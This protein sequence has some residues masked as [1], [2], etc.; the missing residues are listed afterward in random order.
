DWHHPD[1]LTENHSRYVEYLH[2]QVRELLT[3]YGKI[4]G[5][6]FDNLR[7][8]SPQ[9][10]KL[11][12]AERL[13]KTARTLQ[14][15]LIINNRCGLSGDYDTPEQHVGRIQF[16]RPWESCITLGTQWAWKPDDKLKP[17]TDAIRMLVACA[18]GN[19]NLALNTNPMPDGRI[20]P[21][22][23]ESFRKIGKWLKK[24]G[25]SIYE[26]RGGPFVAPDAPRRK[27]GSARD[28]FKLS[29][30]RWWGG[31]THKND[32]IYLHIL[33]WPEDTITLPPIKHKI[34]EHA[35]LTGGKATIRQTADQITV[36]VPPEDRD[37]LDTIVKLR[38]DGPAS[39]IPPMKEP[40]SGSLA[41][42][43]EA[44]ASNVYENAAEYAASRAFDD[45]PDTRW[46][47]D[48]GTH[49]AWLAVDLGEEMTF[50]SARIS[51]PYDR[52]RSFEL[53][54]KKNGS[55][56]TFHKGTT[57]GESRLIEFP[58]ITARH[59]RLNLT[60]TTEGPSIWEFQIFP[61]KK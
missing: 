7:A 28:Q 38:L 48:W 19:G 46:G 14:P 8:V 17:Y 2:G 21:R 60:E 47:C 55:W 54:T 52:V 16:D 4:D 31:S 25:Q 23:V 33:H 22:Q 20:E 42:G 53:Q 45:D 44:T 5:L 15:H 30:G 13:F 50:D 35:V 41:H 34:I 37:P 39:D 24:Y 6:W 9:S 12:D 10:A 29:E 43:K 40:P 3:N 1:Y 49:S 51:E 58:P 32:V 61:P 36:H 26:T 56:H 18:I 11:W 27:F 57:I 59:I